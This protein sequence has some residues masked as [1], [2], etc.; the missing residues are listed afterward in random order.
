MMP[1]VKY[2]VDPIL[3]IVNCKVNKWLEQGENPVGRQRHKP[4]PV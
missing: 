3:L 1:A 2:Q 4:L